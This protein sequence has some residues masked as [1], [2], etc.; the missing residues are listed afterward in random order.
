[1]TDLSQF[2]KVDIHDEK[3]ITTAM[4]DLKYIDPDH[5]TR[6][7]AI[8]FLEFMQTA[9]KEIASRVS[10]DSFEEYYKAYR[11]QRKNRQN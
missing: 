7:D 8:S 1:M 4:N 9:A 6:D 10:I 2:K 5:A 11:A 3:L